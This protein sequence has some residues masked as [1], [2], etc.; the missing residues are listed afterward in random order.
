MGITAISP[1]LRYIAFFFIHFSM[2]FL[3]KATMVRWLLNGQL[4]QNTFFLFQHMAG[5]ILIHFLLYYFL[6]SFLFRLFINNKPLKW[7]DH[8][9]FSCCQVRWSL[10]IG[11]LRNVQHNWPFSFKHFFISL[12][13]LQNTLSWFSSNHTSF[14][15]SLSYLCWSLFLRLMFNF[16]CG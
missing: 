11:T 10:L 14:S 13:F 16:W 1:F 9:S 8:Q 2:T 7:Y 5:R 6:N 12:G 4:L 3:T 15:L